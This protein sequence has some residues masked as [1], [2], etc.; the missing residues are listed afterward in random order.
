MPI[1]MLI[2]F[3]AFF[4]VRFRAPAWVCWIVCGGGCPMLF[5]FITTFVLNCW[6]LHLWFTGPDPCPLNCLVPSLFNLIFLLYEL[7]FFPFFYVSITN[8][9]LFFFF[10]DLPMIKISPIFFYV[11]MTNILPLFCFIF[12][13]EKYLTHNILCI[14]NKYLSYVFFYIYNDKYMFLLKKL[15]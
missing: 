15:K 6:V 8:L 13:S 3:S 7:F 5:S 12:I 11:L 9:S 1:K 14:N 10:L 4:A 2:I